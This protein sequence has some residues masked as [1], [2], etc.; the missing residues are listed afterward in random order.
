MAGRIPF[1]QALKDQILVVDGA[2][3]TQIYAHGVHLSRCFDE[4]NLSNPYLVGKIHHDYIA[5][6][7]RVI[8]TNTFGASRV[9]L[10]RYT[11]GDRIEEVIAAGCKL[12]REAAKV[13]HA[14]GEFSKVAFPK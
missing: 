9:K 14:R 1:K 3:G 2:M 10:D 5:A 13:A 6:G 11:L 4:I 12:A 8:E 7:A